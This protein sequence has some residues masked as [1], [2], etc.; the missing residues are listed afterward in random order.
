MT[1][2]KRGLFSREVINLIR[3]RVYIRIIFSLVIPMVVILAMAGIIGGIEGAPIQFNM[4]FFSIMVS[5]FTVSIYS[6]LVN[7]D[8]L[9][10]DQTLPITT[11]TMIRMKLLGHV[12]ISTPISL[13]VVLAIAALLGE[14]NG[15]LIGLP[16]MLVSIPYMGFVTAYL[17]G[18]WTN[19][20][21]F[22][23]TVFMKY[24]L[25]T[26]IPLM[27]ATVLS[28]LMDTMFW[29]SFVGLGIVILVEL[30]A[31]KLLSIG[32]DRRWND[33]NLSSGSFRR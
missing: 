10:F 24:L 8:Y 17:T 25:F 21:L 14:W 4:V 11:P 19:S 7:M 29:V 32:I 3:G 9:D 12:L 20:M 13:V 33:S 30:G 18:L 5:F 16:V 1:P 15:I 31:I 22:D 2:L 28:Y 6:N 23:S 26:V 27:S